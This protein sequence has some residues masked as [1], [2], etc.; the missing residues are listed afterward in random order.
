MGINYGPELTQ[1]SRRLSRAKVIES[2]LY[3]N[4]EVAPQWLTTN[5]TTRDGQE[6]TGVVGMEDGESVVLKL[7]GD[8]RQKIAKS[9]IARRETLKVSNMPEGLAA[10][11]AAQE[12][13]DLVEYLG[14]LK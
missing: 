14:A 5:I 11:L 1:V 3:P 9:D 2:I 10:G 7:G 4:S 13:L 6:F 12:F 8:Q